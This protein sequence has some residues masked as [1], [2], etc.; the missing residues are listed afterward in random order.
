MKTNFRQEV[1]C[2]A[3]G[4]FNSSLRYWPE[5][6][7][8]AWQVYHLRNMLE[9]GTVSFAYGKTDGTLRFA[10]GT[11]CNVSLKAS[12]ACEKNYRTVCYYD[13]DASGY[14]SFR[15]ENLIIVYD[16]K[17]VFYEKSV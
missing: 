11:L 15:A 6:L 16:W 14:R 3:Y 4:I 2:V 1:M 5:C 17:Q 8:K 9:K 13:L 10:T 12:Q 7:R